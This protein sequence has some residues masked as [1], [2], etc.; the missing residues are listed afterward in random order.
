MSYA[1]DAPLPES[2]ISRRLC[3]ALFLQEMPREN[4]MRKLILLLAVLMISGSLFG[5]DDSWRNRRGDYRYR[6]QNMFELT[7]FGGYRYGG[8]IFADQ[9]SLFGGQDVKVASAG[10][11]GVD[12]AI[13]IGHEYKVELMV[14]RQDTH[15][16][17]GGGLFSPSDQLGAFRITYYHGGL[18][19]PFAVSRSATPY[20][21]VSAGVANLDP[22]VR[23]ASS[24][25]RFSASGGLGVKV[26]FNRNVGLRIEARGYYTSLNYDR[27]CQRC[28]YN[29]NHDLYQ[30][31]TNVGLFLSF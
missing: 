5:Q 23:G 10:N 20:V 25:N 31:E 17:S 7:P 19:I 6:H 12:F 26:P 2:T 14:N 22:Q 4:L 3:P 16:T 21:I 15:F 30:G 9:T 28:F 11:Y 27:Q 18:Q 1:A 8:T 13:P 24:D 29:Y